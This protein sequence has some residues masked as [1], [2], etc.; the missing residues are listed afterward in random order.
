M[1][2]DSHSWRCGRREHWRE[3]THAHQFDVC[4]RTVI[5]LVIFCIVL[6]FKLNS[7]LPKQPG[8]NAMPVWQ[9]GAA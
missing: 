6:L 8:F 3:S 4:G 2:A 5:T 1:A 7:A 9:L